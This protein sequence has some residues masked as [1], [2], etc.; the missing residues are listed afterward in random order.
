MVK[1]YLAS[2]VRM[3]VSSVLTDELLQQKLLQTTAL[4]ANKFKKI[5]ALNSASNSIL[6]YVSTNDLCTFSITLVKHI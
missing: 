6:K 4:N 2:D 3:Y 5:G 1:F